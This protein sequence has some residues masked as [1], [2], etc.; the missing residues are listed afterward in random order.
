MCNDRK[1][2]EFL[3]NPV[4]SVNR[5]SDPNSSTSELSDLD[6]SALLDISDSSDKNEINLDPKTVGVGGAGS[7]QAGNSPVMTAMLKYSSTKKS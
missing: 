7:Q 4:D 3:F 1:F 2:L 5:E 6:C